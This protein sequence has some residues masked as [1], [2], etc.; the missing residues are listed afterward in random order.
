MLFYTGLF[1][2]VI[3]V[4]LDGLGVGI[5][6]GIQKTRVPLLAILIIMLWSGFTVFLAMSIGDGLQHILS[7]AISKNLGAIILISLGL[8]T[9]INLIRTK[10]AETENRENPTMLNDVKKVLLSPQQAD[11]DQSGT[12]SKQEAI[13]L[14]MALALDAFGAGIAA[15]LLHYSAVLTPVLVALMSGMF[16][17]AG[18][19]LGLFLSKYEDIQFFSFIP[20]LL[21]IGIGLF[22]VIS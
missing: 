14:G 5:S 10:K 22:N 6:Y 15:S 8:F 19:K 17:F 16:L 2:L 18:L 3:A 4:S 9:L 13:L 12:I 21:L 1:L 20:S 7:P 11:L